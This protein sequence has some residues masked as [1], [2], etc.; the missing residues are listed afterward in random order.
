MCLTEGLVCFG[1]TFFLS[2]T[3]FHNTITNQKLI[4]HTN[5]RWRLSSGS[6]WL[7][8][9]LRIALL[10]TNQRSMCNEELQ[11]EPQIANSSITIWNQW[12]K[13]LLIA[14]K[15]IFV[16]ITFILKG[17]EICFP[18]VSKVDVLHE[19]PSQRSNVISTWYEW[20]LIHADR[21]WGVIKSEIFTV[22]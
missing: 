16:S 20:L 7:I 15:I 14:A 1:S 10:F 4:C 9:L 5:T 2:V 13:L 22:V 8:K 17:A 19:Q 11:S 18:F 6:Q 3:I 21:L 12:Q